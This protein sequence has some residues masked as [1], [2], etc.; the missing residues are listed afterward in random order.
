MEDAMRGTADAYLVVS[1]MS[2][3]LCLAFFERIL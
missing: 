2:D 1:P 3:E